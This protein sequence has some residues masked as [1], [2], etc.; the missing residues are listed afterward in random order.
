MCEEEEGKRSQRYVRNVNRDG[1]GGVG[2]GG[3]DKEGGGEVQRD[4][5]FEQ[6]Q[7]RD[8]DCVVVTK[9]SVERRDLSHRNIQ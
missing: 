6:R 1:G 3:A 9:Y 4:C 7:R 8:G 5:V 2:R